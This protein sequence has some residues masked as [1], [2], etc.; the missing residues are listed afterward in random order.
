MKKRGYE[1]LPCDL[2]FKRFAENFRK[3]NYSEWILR[4]EGMKAYHD[5]VEPYIE[6]D[7]F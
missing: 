7:I 5:K 1:Y 6:R 2:T 4:R 3:N